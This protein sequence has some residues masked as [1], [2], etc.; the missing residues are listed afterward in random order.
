MTAL[1]TRFPAGSSRGL[2]PLA[3]SGISLI[4]GQGLDRAS[5][6]QALVAG[7]PAAGLLEGPEYSG[8]SPHCGVAL[9]AGFE[10]LAAS[11]IKP[12][13]RRQMSRGT[14]LG[15]LA[16]EAALDHSGLRIAG[17]SPSL[18]PGLDPDRLGVVCG[19]TGTG[20]AP[21]AGQEDPNRILLNMNNAPAAW[22]STRNGITGPALAVSTACASGAY[23]LHQAMLLIHAG[24][25]DAVVC[26]S[27]EALLNPLDLGGFAALM[28]T[29]SRRGDPQGASRPFDLDRDGFVMGEG[30]GYLVLER[31]EQARARGAPILALAHLPGICSE[32]Y[33][34]LSPQP[35]GLGMA[36][37]MELALQSAGLSPGDIGYL[38]A[39]G[40][41]TPLNDRNEAQAIHRVFGSHTQNL[42]V[43]STKSMTGHTLSGAAGL[44][45]VVSILSLMHQV[46]PPTINLDNPDPECALNHV[47]KVARPM[48]FNHVMSNS[49]AFGGHNGVCIFSSP[50]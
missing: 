16:A 10:A 32:A 41:A 19:A 25:C 6:W 30:G 36:R 5:A 4:C 2:A 47:A 7:L 8:G 18:A 40:T 42:A 39:H 13:S 22:I 28:A 1:D 20:Y 26:G 12:R 23:S 33:N 11:V 46:A 45:A 44:E 29:S 37:A 14:M 3:V 49:F 31:L 48:T 50:D 38:N 43:S 27:A 9:P 24:L 21:A 35:E 34:I 15:V 17:D